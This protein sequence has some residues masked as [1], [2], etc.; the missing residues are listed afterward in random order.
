MQVY[1]TNA[2]VTATATPLTRRAA[3]GTFTLASDTTKAASAAGTVR[4]VSGLDAL[5]ALQGL[6]DAGERRKRAVRRGRSALDALDDL[7]LGLLSG[8]TTAESL[9]RLQ[10]VASDLT[11]ESGDARLDAVLAAIRLRIGVELAKAGI[12]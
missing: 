6:E 1:G 4:T 3:S 5:L 10:A 9:Q 7:K 12:R 11:D 8:S 2:L